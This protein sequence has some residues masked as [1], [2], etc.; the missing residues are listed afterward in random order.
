MP[1]ET[2][3]V[4]HGKDADVHRHTIEAVFGGSL[5][6]GLVAGGAAALAIIGL[7]GMF[8]QTLVSI[9]TIGIGAAFLFEGGAIVSRLRDLLHEVTEGRIQTAELGAGVTGETLAGFAGVALGILGTLGMIPEILIAVAAI[10]FGAALIMGAGSNMRINEMSVVYRQEHPMAQRI[11]REA[12][13][14]TTGLQILAGLGA[15]TLG[16]LALVGIAPLVL[17]LVAMLSISGAFL[18][19]DTAVAGRMWTVLGPR[20]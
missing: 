12:V 2:T 17:G 18:L 3:T 9:A 16:I 7:A 13:R 14:G 8:P 4:A 1:S 10:V 15:I 6:G 20:Q 5:A 19:T 11:A